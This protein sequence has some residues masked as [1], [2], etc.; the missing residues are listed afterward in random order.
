MQS[1]SCRER[2]PMN[3]KQLLV[4]VM[5]LSLSLSVYGGT[6]SCFKCHKRAAFD[7]AVVHKP[8]REGGC[9]NCH[10]PHVS[11]FD[12]LLNYR[13]PEICYQCHIREK[14]KFSKIVVFH[15]P[16]K[17]GKCL[18]CHDPHSSSY[19]NLLKNGVPSQCFHCHKDM[20]KKYSHIHVPFKKGRCLVCHDAH[21]SS[22]YRLLK[23]KDP[24]ICLKCHRDSP[25]IRKVHS[26][27]NMKDMKCLYCHN[28]H[29]S[30][31]KGLLRNVLH[32][33]FAKGECGK[34]HNGKIKEPAVCFQCH[35]EV[36]SAFYTN[37][38]H[39]LSSG[40]NPCVGCHSPHASDDE[41][42]LVGK[43]VALCR[44][45]HGY[46]YQTKENALYV[47]PNWDQCTDC[48][49]PH[50]SNSLAMLYESG[51]KLC[52]RC[53][54]TQGKFTHP[55]GEKV[56]DP[57]NGQPITCVTCHDPMGTAFKYNLKRSGDKDLCVQ[58]HRG[59]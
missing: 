20:S 11:R 55:V 35:A 12:G 3:W 44:K 45:C 32:K 21:G 42:L 4:C 38:N 39:L 52:A 25:S 43:E 13:T 27:Y 29:G 31:R 41:K 59:Y 19:K 16:V 5:V 18:T 56:K 33:P 24:V 14:V 15:S 37:H 58:C 49:N 6:T 47:H 17:K 46:V 23:G 48:H 36:K 9:I 54:E 8:V 1:L 30:S 10:S 50:G 53:H 28:P 40:A 57:R 51:N 34:C 22:D 2:C 26:G 7:K